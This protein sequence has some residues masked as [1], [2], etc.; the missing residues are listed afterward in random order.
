MPKLPS[1]QLYPSDWLRDEIAGCSIA[2]Q[3]LWLRIMFVMHDATPYGYAVDRHGIPLTNSVLARRCGVSQKQLTIL[4]REL[5]GASVIKYDSSQRIYSQRMV[6]DAKL[7]EKWKLDKQRQ[8][9]SPPPVHQRV[10]HASQEIPSVSSSS[11]SVLK[12]KDINPAQTPRGMSTTVQEQKRKI[13]ARD[14]RLAREAIAASEAQVGAGPSGN[15][16]RPVG[17]LNQREYLEFCELRKR[18]ELPEGVSDFSLYLDHLERTVPG[19]VRKTRSESE[20]QTETSQE[21]K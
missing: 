1:I 20:S 14:T 18:K 2:A 4:L 6:N 19:F 12:D 15:G 17:I 8:R 21:K 3:G 10:H 11:S 5:V 13:E 9:A 16:G 7:R